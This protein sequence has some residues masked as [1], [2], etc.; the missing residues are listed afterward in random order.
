M[1][2]IFGILIGIGLMCSATA[3][4][5]PHYTQYILNNYILNPALS[6]IEN[7]MDVKMSTRD[8]WIG[9]SGA[10]KTMYLTIHA[11]L[12]K[13]DYK[14][15]ATSYSVPGE[16]PRG[17]NYWQ[18][19]TASEPHHG[20]G[21]SILNDKTG[22]YNRFSANV[23]YA[24]HIGLSA[25]TNMSAGF[26]GGIMK[27]SRDA[28]KSSYSGTDQSDPAQG[29]VA[30]IYRIRPDLS[31][32]IWVYSAD[33]FFGLSAQQIIP[34]KVAF[35]DDTLGFKIIP[36]LFATAGYR[37]L[38][39]EDINALPSVM[40]KYISPLDPQFDVNIK[41]QYRDLFWL[42]GSYRFKDGYAG[43]LGLN[44][45]NTFNIGYAY[46]VTTSNLRT[47]SRGTHEIVI[48]F[49]LGNKYDDSCPRNVW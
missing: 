32:G 25:R 19:Y 49:L 7:Y 27:I 42:G 9:L 40:I 14:T 3:Q 47:V 41:L 46:D 34:Q 28:T 48:G 22:L 15:S 8:Q 11:P 6:G 5:R 16:N 13:K 31:A 24:Y 35:A 20:I 29:T 10:P 1:K 23:S 12:G 38:L 30:D 45:A 36:H 18:N 21:F 33:Y 26:A 37:F 43:M 39:N 2:K 4:Q 17:S 44:V